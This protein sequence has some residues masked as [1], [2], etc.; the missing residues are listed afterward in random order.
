M[1]EAK[2]LE[3]LQNGFGAI[4]DIKIFNVEKFFIKIF[5]KNNFGLAFNNKKQYVINQIP[6]LFIEFI[7]LICLTVLILV[8]INKSTNFQVFFL[9]WH[10]LDLRHLD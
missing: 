5:D 3:S 7:T 4:R 10:Y 8:T 2:T 6:R 1:Y 9:L